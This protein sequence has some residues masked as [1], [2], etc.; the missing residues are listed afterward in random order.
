MFKFKNN[1][2]TLGASDVY[3]FNNLLRIKGVYVYWREGE[4]RVAGG[5]GNV[6]VEG[7]RMDRANSQP[8]TLVLSTSLQPHSHFFCPS[9]CVEKSSGFT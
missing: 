9:C 3:I 7:G 1:I 4:G 2:L 5:R 8:R 6:E